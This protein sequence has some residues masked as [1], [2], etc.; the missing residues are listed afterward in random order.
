M[1]SE[2]VHSHSYELQNI[3]MLHNHIQILCTAHIR[4]SRQFAVGILHKIDI[5]LVS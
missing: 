5:I 1:N 4:P 2:K 3:A